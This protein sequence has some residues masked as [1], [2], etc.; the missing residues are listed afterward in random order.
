MRVHNPRRAFTLIELL[1]VIAII[2]ILAAILFPV[3]A[4]AREKART[5]S[6]ASNEKQI[7]L[8]IIQ[9]T[10]DYDET[11]PCCRMCNG[12]N[13]FLGNQVTMLDWRYIIQPYEKNTQILHC[14][15]NT[16]SIDMNVDGNE[17]GGINQD[18]RMATTN[19][20]LQGTDGFSYGTPGV[21]ALAALQQ[22]AQSLIVVEQGN[23]GY[24]PD[25]AAWNA[26]GNCG[27]AHNGDGNFGFV[28]GHVKILTW[29]ST[30]SP[31]VLWEWDGLLSSEGQ[32]GQQG[33]TWG[34]TGWP[35]GC[36]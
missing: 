2:A 17:S 9:Y 24:G 32:Y 35:V 10:Q 4:K 8:G 20:N 36:N 11:F 14:P 5:A 21:C 15:S 1:V 19:G 12:P 16:N 13:Q 18:Y 27:Y 3:F 28:D 31:V 6:C 25:M 34:A 30:F 7:L 22:P 29:R 26:P 23:A 33:P